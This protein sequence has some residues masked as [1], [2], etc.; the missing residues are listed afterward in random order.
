[1]IAERPASVRAFT[2]VEV[3]VALGATAV[4]LA[5][6]ATAVP[7]LL[8]ARAGAEA[9]LAR[10]AAV[11]AV[12][13]RL[14]R[15]LASAR[16]EPFEVSAAPPALRFTGGD[17]PGA[18]IAYVA[19]GGALARGEAPRFAA[20]PVPPPVTTLL[21]GVTDLD[22][23][24]LDGAEWKRSWRGAGPPRALRIRLTFD[25]GDGVETTVVVPTG[26]TGAS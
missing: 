13:G 25:D 7:A 23:R 11:D 19:Q 15:E 6:L 18:R 24:V 14:E 4:V 20:D 8:R 21:A 16:A 9:H 10:S 17:D 22:V 26:R 1:M 12:L 2:L 3:L 5:A